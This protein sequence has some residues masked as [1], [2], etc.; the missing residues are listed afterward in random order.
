MTYPKDYH[1]TW[2]AR[3]DPATAKRLLAIEPGATEVFRFDDETEAT[4][5][6]RRMYEFIHAFY[7]TQRFVISRRT[8]EL[9]VF[10]PEGVKEG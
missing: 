6:R 4:R 3:H 2:V 1:K 7:G 8:N 9:H 10:F 5:I